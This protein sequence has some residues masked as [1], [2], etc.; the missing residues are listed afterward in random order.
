MALVNQKQC[1]AHLIQRPLFLDFV[2][3]LIVPLDLVPFRQLQTPTLALLSHRRQ[4]ESASRVE[5]VAEYRREWRVHYLQ[6]LGKLEVENG[7]VVV[8]VLPQECMV[9]R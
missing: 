6:A 2:R 8:L 4:L 9:Q 3:D 7:E 5:T 1:P